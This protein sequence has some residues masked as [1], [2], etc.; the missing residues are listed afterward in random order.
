M[1][2]LRNLLDKR[3]G[4]DAEALRL[5]HAIRDMKIDEGRGQFAH[6]RS[7]CEAM[8]RP[9]RIL[10]ARGL[11]FEHIG[12]LIQKS[13]VGNRERDIFDSVFDCGNFRNQIIRDGEFPLGMLI[14][15]KAYLSQTEEERIAFHLKLRIDSAEFSD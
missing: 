13:L 10:A 4:D 12:Q 7:A 1:G 15:K 8:L 6:S 9:Y 11:G 14:D 3:L 2:W 5:W